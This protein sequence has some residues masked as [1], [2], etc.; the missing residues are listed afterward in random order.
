MDNKEALGGNSGNRCTTTT[1]I[2][3]P[4]ISKNFEGLILRY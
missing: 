4:R 1:K 3:K 2:Q